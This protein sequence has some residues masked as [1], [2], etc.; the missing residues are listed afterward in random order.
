MATSS[1][2]DSL[3]KTKQD[4]LKNL[5]LS[6]DDYDAPYFL[7]TSYQ[8]SLDGIRKICRAWIDDCEEAIDGCKL[9]ELKQGLSF[10]CLSCDSK[11]MQLLVRGLVDRRRPITHVAAFHHNSLGDP[12]QTLKWT[13]QMLAKITEKSASKSLFEINDF[14]DEHWQGISEYR[15]TI[16]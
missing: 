7:L 5:F 16:S 2:L 3:D 8:D 4:S 13:G 15:D 10:I 14:S 9:L 11:T 6:F 12:M 1:L